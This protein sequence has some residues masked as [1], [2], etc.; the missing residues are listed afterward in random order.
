MAIDYREKEREFLDGLEEATGRGLD[1]WMTAIGAANLAHRNDVI[2]WLRQQGFMF[3][4]ASWLERVYHNGG[5]PIYSGVIP[6]RSRARREKKQATALD[7]PIQ[8]R[9][10]GPPATTATAPAEAVATVPLRSE[11]RALELPADA[12]QAALAHAKGLKPLA[13]ALL[14]HVSD[15]VPDT[16]FVASGQHITFRRNNHD[17]GALIPAA[18]DLKLYLAIAHEPPAAP[19]QAA[20]ATPP[21]IRLDVALT[22]MLVLNDVRQIT[23]D[24]L[25]LIAAATVS[26][27]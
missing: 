9:A 2:D 27:K 23:A 20:K 11:P 4:K 22:H 6:E 14:R 24:V 13:Q 12:L 5:K 1:G 15:N 18:R 21:A 10:D 3:S 8:A 26:P 16:E 19:W 25:R 7:A 17:F